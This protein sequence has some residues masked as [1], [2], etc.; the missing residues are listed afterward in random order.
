[1]PYQQALTGPLLA[2]VEEHQVAPLLYEAAG[3]S[4]AWVQQV[5]PVQAV[6]DRLLRETRQALHAL[7]PYLALD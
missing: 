2:A 5:E 3:Q 1:M 7:R 6:M 4:V